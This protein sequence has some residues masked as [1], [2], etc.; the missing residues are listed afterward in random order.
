MPCRFFD[1]LPGWGSEP[2]QDLPKNTPTKSFA[3]G[4][5]PENTKKQ[6]RP[7]P[8][9]TLEIS[10]R[11]NQRAQVVRSLR[12]LLAAEGRSGECRVQV[13]RLQEQPKGKRHGPPLLAFL[14]GGTHH[15]V[16]QSFEKHPNL[17]LCGCWR[18][19]C[20]DWLKVERE[21]KGTLP[22]KGVLI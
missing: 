4:K 6:R 17:V 16:A 9:G 8:H 22:M 14:L 19:S 21:A 2:L 7:F 12:E 13:E 20:W 11:R 10:A 15:G 5:R 1:A 18:D 3:D